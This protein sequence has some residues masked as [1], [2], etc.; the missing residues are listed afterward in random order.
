[1]LTVRHTLVA[2]ATGVALSLV[3][4]T[5]AWT[6]VQGPVDCAQ[7]S[8]PS[9]LITVSTPGTPGNQGGSS[10]VPCHDQNG[11][12]VPCYEPDLGWLSSDGCY[13]RPAPAIEW[14]PYHNAG[15]GTWYSRNC[16]AGDSYVYNLLW[17]VGPAPQLESLAQQAVRY[18]RLPALTI[19]LN[20]APPAP[21]IVY[22][23]TWLWIDPA[24][25]GAR[26]ATASAGGLSVTATATPISVVWSTGD[27]EAV[28]CAGPGTA[29][30]PGMDSA[31]ASPTCGHTYA[32]ASGSGSFTLRATVTW[33]ISWVGGGDTGTEP[34]LTTTGSARIRVVEAGGLNNGSVTD[35]SR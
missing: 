24:S 5:P 7:S 25:W 33:Q 1:M 19:R 13:Y 18:L 3:S 4:T 26:S 32:A 30:R 28:T 31:A 2:A 6:G 15:P 8:D 23:P 16:P 17:W 20:P 35:G 21:Q 12:V 27:G 22:V 10:S 34:P 29:W 14:P 9:C 11:A